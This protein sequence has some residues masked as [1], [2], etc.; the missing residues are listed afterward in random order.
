MKLKMDWKKQTK[1]FR[2]RQEVLLEYI[3]IDSWSIFFWMPKETSETIFSGVAQP[4]VRL[5][6][7]GTV[8]F[9]DM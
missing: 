7:V 3:G 5:R 4:K 1:L 8:I 9:T 2:N 6:S